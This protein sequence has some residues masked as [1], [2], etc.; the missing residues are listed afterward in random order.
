MM[1]ISPSLTMK[2]RLENIGEA[3]SLR[4][5]RLRISRRASMCTGRA[6]MRHRGRVKCGCAHATIGLEIENN[7]E[8]HIFSYILSRNGSCKIRKDIFA[9]PQ[10]QHI[11]LGGF[12]VLFYYSIGM[13]SPCFE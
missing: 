3:L 2:F 11:T 1:T 6:E 10:Q 13:P 12:H 4:H 7:I 5:A 9:L 8:F